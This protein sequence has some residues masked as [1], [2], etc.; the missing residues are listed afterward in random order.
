MIKR[1]KMR[2]NGERQLYG[3]NQV[4]E[5]TLPKYNNYNY[6]KISKYKQQDS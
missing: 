4:Y 1:R 3:R 6:V 5:L 2:L